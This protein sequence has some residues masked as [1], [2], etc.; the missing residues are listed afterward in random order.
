[1][2]NTFLFRN[3]LLN[4]ERQKEA[5]YKVFKICSDYNKLRYRHTNRDLSVTE[6]MNLNDKIYKLCHSERNFFSF[7]KQ[8]YRSNSDVIFNVPVDIIKKIELTFSF[9][10]VVLFFLIS[11]S[12]FY[13]GIVSKEIESFFYFMSLLGYC[14]FF[15]KAIINLRKIN[16]ALF[17]VN[18]MISYL[19]LTI[20]LIPFVMLFAGVSDFIS[21]VSSIY[22]HIISYYDLV[23][24]FYFF[25]FIS[26][27]YIIEIIELFN[28]FKTYNYLYD[29]KF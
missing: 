29:N 2:I 4:G 9:I 15:K 22:K 16:I 7:A 19:L 24:P 25:L 12:I 26:M 8:I 17:V 21:L 5:F 3:I 1:M 23:L 14:F 6:D 11:C 18:G 28:L 20:S 27:C 10:N 13:F